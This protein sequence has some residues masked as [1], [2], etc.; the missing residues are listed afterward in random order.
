MRLDTSQGR[1][2][3]VSAPPFKVPRRDAYSENDNV[4]YQS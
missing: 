1:I 2:N 4:L 3:S